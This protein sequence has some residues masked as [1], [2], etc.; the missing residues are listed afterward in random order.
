MTIQLHTLW[1]WP[2]FRGDEDDQIVSLDL[3]WQFHRK[4]NSSENTIQN[5]RKLNGLKNM[6]WKEYK[7]TYALQ[8]ENKFN[9][10]APLV[11]HKTYLMGKKKGFCIMC[12]LE[13][14]AIS[15]SCECYNCRIE[16]CQGG[17]IGGIHKS[18]KAVCFCL[19][20]TAWLHLSSVSKR[21]W[22]GPAPSLCLL[23]FLLPHFL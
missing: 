23:L 4:P 14:N 20:S 19:S 22:Q 9:F 6:N 13:R 18:C 5:K 3:T 10:S 7:D 17:A 16:M 11:H 15:L 8:G 2:K 12:P 1:V 21:V